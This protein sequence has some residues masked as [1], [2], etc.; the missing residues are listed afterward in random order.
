MLDG[1]SGGRTITYTYNRLGE[2]TN[3]IMSGDTHRWWYTY[4]SL[5]Q[6]KL[7]R[8]NTFLS[9]I[10]DADYSVYW[11]A[12]MVQT[13][14][15][16]NQSNTFLYDARDRLIQINSPANDLAPFSASYTYHNNNTID[17]AQ[18]RQPATPHTHVRA[19]YR[20]T[21]DN[22]N[23]LK[24]ATYNWW[25]GSSWQ[26][27]SSYD[28]SGITYDKDGNLSGLTR[29][30]ETGSANTY[31]YQYVSGAN[32]LN[33]IVKNSTDIAFSH[34][35]NGN[36]KTIGSGYNITATTYNW[37]NLPTAIAKSGTTYN[38]RYDHAGL[39]VYKQEG[40]NIHYMRGAYGEVLAVYKNGSHDYWN[41]VRPDGTVIG[42]RE[43]S[44]RMYYHRDHL[45][46]TRAIVNASGTV[47]QTYDYYPFGLL[48][49]GRY[50]TVGTV[51]NSREKFTAHELDTEV[52]LYYMVARRYAAE[53]GRFMSVDP[54]ADEYSDWSPYNY[55]FNNPI[56]Y[57]DP[58]GKDGI[59]INLK[60]TGIAGFGSG[61]IDFSLGFDYHEY[62]F[63]ATSGRSIG[64]GT[65][66]GIGGNAVGGEASVFVSFYKGSSP[67]G[68]RTSA[69]ID[70][71]GGLGTFSA[72]TSG[73][74][75]LKILEPGMTS[76]EGLR[77]A[78][79]NFELG[80]GIGLT[81]GGGVA[82]SVKEENVIFNFK[83]GGSNTN[84]FSLG[85]QT[86][87]ARSDATNVVL[88]L[89]KDLKD[90]IK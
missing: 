72:S 74:N 66:F 44:T 60:F 78:K 75:A 86:G 82:A 76:S 67:Q 69:T 24:S 58:D 31:S 11:P 47:E 18:F 63:F 26:N 34:D 9:Q 48:M 51:V 6:L 3:R 10:T 71:F 81:T 1:L 2:V 89:E 45:G 32:K 17:F 29:R 55:V 13:E 50:K 68:D 73:E 79:D 84:P 77:N 88:N 27:P 42:R 37:K 64:A 59:K 36:V 52:D 15:L 40:D 43:G 22:R 25:N 65:T 87:V 14:V 23:Q 19:R 80:I 28:V 33:K 56:N 53:F 39:R 30:T 85:D 21:Y 35:G 62:R 41:I 83:I 7:V 8:S 46:T 70:A 61:G 16:G 5:G 90:E 12:G 38:Y 49:P 54:L 20:H 4:N 57:N